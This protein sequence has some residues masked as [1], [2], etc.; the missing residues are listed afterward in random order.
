MV[1]SLA[2]RTFQLRHRRGPPPRALLRAAR[3][4]S[5]AHGLLRRPRPRPPERVLGAGRPHGRERELRAAVLLPRPLLLRDGRLP[6][7][8][9]A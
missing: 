5:H 2:D 7:P 1:R 4:A 9:G 6:A 8:P 3:A